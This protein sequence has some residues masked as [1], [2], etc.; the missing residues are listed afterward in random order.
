MFE[1]RNEIRVFP[2][3]AQKLLFGTLEGVIDG[4]AG[5]MKL[6][7]DGLIALPHRPILEDDEFIRGK[8]FS[9]QLFAGD[10]VILQNQEFFGIH[11]IMVGK[12]VLERHAALFMID[13]L[14]Q[15]DCIREN[16]VFLTKGVFDGCEALPAD[17]LNGK[18]IKRNTVI[19]SKI[20][21]GFEE[22]EAAFLHEVVVTADG[23]DVGAADCPDQ[24]VELT[25]D[26]RG[27]LPIIRALI[28]EHLVIKRT[29]ALLRKLGQCESSFLC[30]LSCFVEVVALG[31]LL[32]VFKRI[33]SI[34]LPWN[35]WKIS[36]SAESVF[37]ITDAI[38]LFPASIEHREF[39][40]FVIDIHHGSSFPE[41]QY[42]KK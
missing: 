13:R 38:G 20:P 37:P 40:S 9:E 27:K 36:P 5:S 10:E 35:R 8:R 23:K 17:A 28:F 30:L 29:I 41:R 7:G 3:E 18:A 15:G 12:A 2:T 26:V 4:F 1:R 31:V 14:I 11:R 32:Q 39:S 19:R 34:F 16:H 22:A 33:I 21:H 6:G 42:V 25:D 24:G